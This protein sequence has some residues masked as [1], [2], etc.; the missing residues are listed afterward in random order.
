M[1][2]CLCVC[3]SV[4]PSISAQHDSP[5]AF[6]RCTTTLKAAALSER[7]N[8]FTHSLTHSPTHSLFGLS[9]PLMHSFKVNAAARTNR[10]SFAPIH[11]QS[12]NLAQGVSP[13]VRSFV[14]F[15]CG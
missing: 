15:Y 1:E 7:T 8:S 4:R 14:W 6:T 10:H 11:S 5:P 12:I 13:F 2:V 3:L 9:H